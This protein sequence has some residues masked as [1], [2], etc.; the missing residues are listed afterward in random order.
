MTTAEFAESQRLQARWASATPIEQLQFVAENIHPDTRPAIRPVP[1][2]SRI[3]DKVVEGVWCGL[4]WMTCIGLVA[5]L[6][7]HIILALLF[8]FLVLR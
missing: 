5:L 8:M 2:S 4:F 3:I 1:P 7:A 6:P